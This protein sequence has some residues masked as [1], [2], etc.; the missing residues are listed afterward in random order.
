MTQEHRAGPGSHGNTRGRHHSGSDGHG[1]MTQE[2]R[3]GQNSHHSLLDHVLTAGD[4][5]AAGTHDDPHEGVGAC[6]VQLSRVIE[7][8]DTAGLILLAALGPEVLWR[9]VVGLQAPSPALQSV[10]LKAAEE[11]APDTSAPD[12]RKRFAA[13]RSRLPVPEPRVDARHAEQIGAWTLIPE[14]PDWPVQLDDLGLQRPVVLW[15]RGDR[16]ALSRLDRSV[17]VVGA[18]NASGYGAAVTR[19]MAHELAAAQWCVVSGGAYGIDAVAHTAALEAGAENGA[20]IAVLACGVDRSYPAGN[21]DLLR[22]I[23]QRGVVLSEVPLGCAPT[24]YRFLQRNRLIAALTRATVVTEAA[25][26][27]GSLNTARHAAGLS[28][29]VAAV[30]GDVLVGGSAGCHRLIRDDHAVLV[31]NAAELM[32]LVEPLGN[33]AAQDTHRAESARDERPEDGLDPMLLRLFDALPLRTDA[34]PSHLCAVSGLSPG[35]V[36]TGLVT[37]RDA[38]LAA[39]SLLGWRRVGSR[40]GRRTRTDGRTGS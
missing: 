8:S 20:T 37:L 10:Y 24:R 1:A 35:E 19:Q 40:H 22:R 11:L 36:L 33:A 14:D 17:A 9:S 21:A 28:R 39:D 15:G 29:E 3:S 38:G 34:D 5:A 13:W 7:P 27:S 4:P 32:E 16:G 26:R 31:S 30:P 18:R 25:W 2:H 23:A 6:R 12:L